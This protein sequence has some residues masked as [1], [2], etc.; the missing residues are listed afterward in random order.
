VYHNSIDFAKKNF[1]ENLF[2]KASFFHIG[3]GA[4]LSR[5]EGVS[6]CNLS[7]LLGTGLEKELEKTANKFNKS[8]IE[9]PSMIELNRSSYPSKFWIQ[10]R[11]IDGRIFL[12]K[13]LLQS[14]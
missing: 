9:S 14:R 6:E 2:D 7:A 1:T 5:I 3:L 4:F 8:T 10:I 11:A 13:S 12:L